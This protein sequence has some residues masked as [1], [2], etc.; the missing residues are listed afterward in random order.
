P[1]FNERGALI[2]L[3]YFLLAIAFGL[4]FLARNRWVR[5]GLVAALAGAFLMSAISYRRHTTDPMDY[6]ALGNALAARAG[7][8]ALICLRTRWDVTPILYYLLEKRDQLIGGDYAE[9]VRRN[10][11]AT[12]WAVAIYE[13]DI[14]GEMKQALEGYN[15]G[16]SIRMPYGKAIMYRRLT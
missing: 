3:P 15:S 6:R 11:N 16:E 12:V 14:A 5:A 4:E 13:N 10:P 7:P 8:A 1:I 9:A 2:F